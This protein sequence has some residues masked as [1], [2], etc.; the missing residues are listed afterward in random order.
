MKKI[1]ILGAGKSSPVLI[2][3]Y[4]ERAQQE[5]WHVVVADQSEENAKKRIQGATQA[6]ALALDIFDEAARE[7]AISSADLVI[8]LLPPS[9]HQLAAQTCIKHKRHL[10]TASYVSQE[11]KKL[12][13][14]AQSAGVILLNEV[15]VDPGI[16]HMSAMKMLDEIRDQG[17]KI[18]RFESFTGGL[19]APE[20][21]DNP[22]GYKFTWNPRNVVLAG[23]GAAATFIQEGYVK[24]IPYH[25]LFR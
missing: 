16:D 18:L 17:G 19:V 2:R 5:H 4:L 23:Q 9:M 24:Y 21:D 14:E 6:S 12:D 11:M 3:Y 13:A 25:R 22:W 7:E 10:V 15:G 20:S 1:L 8:S